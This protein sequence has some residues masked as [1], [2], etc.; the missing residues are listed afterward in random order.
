[1]VSN[2]DYALG[3]V[4]DLVQRHCC[5]LTSACLP[6]YC[7]SSSRNEIVAAPRDAYNTAAAARSRS[8]WQRL[9]PYLPDR[10]IM[11]VCRD[12][13]GSEA[14]DVIPMKTDTYGKTQ[15][16]QKDTRTRTVC[17]RILYR[18]RY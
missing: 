10:S 3:V 13:N 7:I 2:Q 9:P 4:L 1:M 5:S 17:I 12:H 15:T 16:F 6:C 14:H 8:V 11:Y 18:W